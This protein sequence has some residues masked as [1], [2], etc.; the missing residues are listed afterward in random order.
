MVFPH[1][2]VTT[3]HTKTS[4]QNFQAY[5]NAD[6]TCVGRGADHAAKDGRPEGVVLSE[7][8]A[9]ERCGLCCESLSPHEAF[10][11]RNSLLQNDSLT[12]A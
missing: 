2:A 3:R 4:H 5:G 12:E 6:T 11:C 7:K 8:N 1:F 10:G 9:T